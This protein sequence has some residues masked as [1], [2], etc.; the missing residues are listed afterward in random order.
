MVKKAKKA[1]KKKKK[2]A[3]PVKVE[4]YDPSYARRVSV[5]IG[6]VPLLRTG[7]LAFG[8]FAKALGVSHV[9]MK[10]WR[11][12]GSG[13]YKPEFVFAIKKAEVELRKNIALVKEGVELSKIHKAVVKRAK[14]YSKVKV[15]KEPVVTGPKHPPYSRFTKDDL[16][17]YAKNAL[18]LKLNK[19]LSKGA[20]ENAIRK[21][22]DEMTT[23]ELKVVK[24]EEEF[25]PSDITAAKY[26]DQN[27][28]KK[29]E[30]WTDTQKLDVESQS[31]A[32]ILAKAGIV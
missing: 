26:C 24:V 10:K 18:G 23:E 25:I 32:D 19:K 7:G 11:T 21:R 28:G 16:I 27:M 31:L 12:Q 20:I 14:G 30:Q 3:K 5:L 22:I 13:I 6:Q 9:T 15:T 2:V 17:T 4:K 29:E 1:V 8:V